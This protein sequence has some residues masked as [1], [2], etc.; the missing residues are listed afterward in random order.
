VRASLPTILGAGL[1][2]LAGC[3][4][5]APE[6]SAP[7]P[8]DLALAV[9]LSGGPEVDQALARLGGPAGLAPSRGWRDPTGQ[10]LVTLLG[11]AQLSRHEQSPSLAL[12]AAPDPE[13][14]LGWMRSRGRVVSR[15]GGRALVRRAAASPHA[16]YSLGSRALPGVDEEARDAA[17][18]PDLAL[19]SRGGTSAALLGQGVEDAEVAWGLSQAEEVEARARAQ[20]GAVLRVGLA[21]AGLGRWAGD[22]AGL[23]DALGGLLGPDSP[24]RSAWFDAA[25]R[26]LTECAWL[27]LQAELADGALDWSLALEAAPGSALAG[28]LPAAPADPAAL[29][30]PQLSAAL[31][32]RFPGL[33]EGLRVRLEGSLRAVLSGRL[34]EARLVEWLAPAAP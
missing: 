3:R 13:A 12:L 1:L 33:R 6:A 11:F 14:L 9:V 32:Q 29:P 18:E 30:G 20:G 8:T 28:R 15:A 21:P 27:E 16:I 10:G 17:D 31:E 26:L 7:R 4:P 23:A 25:V 34:P 19:V 22:G 5:A 2:A 24:D